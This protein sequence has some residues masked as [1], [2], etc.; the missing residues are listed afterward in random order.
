M[1]QQQAARR[2]EELRR[3][4]EHNN[5]LY[6]ENDAPELEDFEYDA[7]TRELKALEKEFPALVTEASPTQRVNEAPSG[8]FAKV[9]HTVKRNSTIVAYDSTT[10]VRVG[11]TGQNVRGTSRSHFGRIN[12][13]H[14]FVVRLSVFGEDILNFGIELVAVHFQSAFAH[15]DTAEGL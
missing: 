8:R 11:K 5:R 4:I 10:T 9:I 13:E 6:Y 3:I 2:A 12:V 7:L 15:T 1:T 14:A